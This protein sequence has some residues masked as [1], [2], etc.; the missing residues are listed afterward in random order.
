MM[1]DTLE[2]LERWRERAAR[3]A[4]ALVAAD[5]R[6]DFE[7]EWTWGIRVRTEHAEL[8]LGLPPGMALG[9]GGEL[10]ATLIRRVGFL[11]FPL[12]GGDVTSSMPPFVPSLTLKGLAPVQGDRE[13]KRPAGVV[14]WW[15]HAEAW[16][17][18]AKRYGR[19]QSAERLAERAGF[20]YAELTDHLKHEPTTWRAR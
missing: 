13:P 4:A 1:P 14:A 17:D 19:D 20:S 7:I 10:A 11:A 9:S 16:E 6:C 5:G 8:Y 2:I 3:L 18:Y 12:V 15:E